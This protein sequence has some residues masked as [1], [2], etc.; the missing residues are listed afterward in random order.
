MKTTTGTHLDYDTLR[1]LCLAAGADDVGFVPVS[2]AAINTDRKDIALAFPQTKMLISIVCKM[3]V[4]PTRSPARSIANNEF[5]QAGHDVNEVCRAI[6]QELQDLGIPALNP[7]M[8]FPMEAQNWPGKMW[9]ISHKN[10]AEAAGM[11]KMGIH[12]NVIHP[13]FGNFILLGTVLVDYELE[14]YSKAL[15]YNPCVDCKLCVAACPVGAISLDGDFNF[16]SCYTHNYRE[17]M[18][19]FTDWTS[20]VIES[21]DLK[22]YRSQVDDH[23][24]VSVWQSLTYGANYKAAYCVAVCPA[25]EDLFDTYLNNKAK[26]VKEIVQ[27]LQNKEER[28]YVMDQSDAQAYVEK[29]YPH[30]ETKIVSSQVNPSTI[31][32]F[33]L[34]LKLFFQRTQAKDL[35][36]TYH[37][38]FTGKEALEST[39]VI[40]NQELSVSN[41]LQ[42]TPSISIIADSEVW[43]RFL[44]KDYS[45]FW[46]LLR[47]KIKI[48]GNPKLLLAFQKC[49]PI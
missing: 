33:L 7:S 14:Q 39:I 27:P 41:G 22:D 15:D 37:F 29:R 40:S 2:H 26:H 34:G 43:L 11:G 24:T 4:Y 18:G 10:V 17:F 23:E 42:G 38:T 47:R 28:I 12:R 13:K 36:A 9:V 3:N 46:A 45:M 21:K 31:E 16:S 35:E 25:G 19:G 44:N 20:K 6:V 32:G 1:A 8:A 48:K 30:K 5:H 49:F